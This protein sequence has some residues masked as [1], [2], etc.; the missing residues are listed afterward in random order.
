MS[1]SENVLTSK[2]ARSSSGSISVGRAAGSTKEELFMSGNND[3]AAAAAADGE[4][5]GK[6]RQESQAKK[7]MP[8]S[9]NVYV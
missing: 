6:E 8:A 7:I 1:K 9:G 4:A 3:A 2:K 5:K